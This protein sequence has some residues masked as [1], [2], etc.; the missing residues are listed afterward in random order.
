MAHGEGAE[1]DTHLLAMA[2]DFPAL[3]SRI[4]EPLDL[5]DEVSRMIMSIYKTLD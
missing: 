5:L 4:D 1:L 3:R 2:E